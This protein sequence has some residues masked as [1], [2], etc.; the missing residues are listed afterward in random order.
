[1]NYADKIGVPYAVFLGDDEIREG[2]AAVKDMRTGQ[3]VKVP[4]VEAAAVIRAG[5]AELE[6][7]TPILDKGEA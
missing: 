6:K 2:A 5:L 3:Q 4:A 1:M 7:G